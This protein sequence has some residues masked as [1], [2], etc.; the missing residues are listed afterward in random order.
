MR[1]FPLWLVLLIAVLVI[2]AIL[3]FLGVNVRV[4]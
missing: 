3:W 4:N 1:D 2:L